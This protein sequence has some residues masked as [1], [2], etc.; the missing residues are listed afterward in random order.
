MPTLVYR[1]RGRPNAF[2]FGV[3]DSPITIGR[4][5]SSVIVVDSA[6]VSRRHAEIFSDDE[7]EA[8]AIRDLA[9]VNGTFVNGLQVHSHPLADKDIVSCGE[10]LME[11]RRGPGSGRV[12]I[13][14]N[15]EAFASGRITGGL[16]T[17]TSHEF[18]IEELQPPPESLSD[19]RSASSGAG[20]E[21]GSLYRRIHELE[22][23]TKTLEEELVLLRKTIGGLRQRR[24]GE[25]SGGERIEVEL[26]EESALTRAT[27]DPRTATTPRRDELSVP[28]D[29][30]SPEVASA[31]STLMDLDRRRN[32]V[33]ERV[34]GMIAHMQNADPVEDGDDGDDEKVEA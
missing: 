6:G 11:F 34:L 18:A 19:E 25:H 17:T 14:P 4:D 2:V 33:L 24:A 29:G 26:P 27:Y 10:F 28:F 1:K 9:S 22:G 15:R 7:G 12:Q 32:S 16:A 20:P 5:S 13:G 31:F 30:L 3:Q 21:I 23:Y 8:W